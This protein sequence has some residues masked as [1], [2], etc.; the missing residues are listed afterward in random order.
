LTK[1]QIAKRLTKAQ[2]VAHV[3][4]LEE[5]NA[6]LHADLDATRSKLAEVEHCEWAL[7]SEYEDLKN[8]LES[9]RTSHDVVVKERAKVQ[10]PERV[11]LQRFQDS[12]RKRLAELRCDI[13][14]SVAMLSGRSV[15]FPTGDSLFDFLEWFR[16]QVAA[17][18]TTFSE[19]N[20]NITCYGLI[21][22]SQMLAGEGC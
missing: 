15:E 11:K 12:V 5:A 17:M 14:A 20:E 6:R 8:D 2:Q 18:A 4:E 21:G 9:M 3:A 19:C 10:K 13:E 7:T 1:S 22:V 16:A